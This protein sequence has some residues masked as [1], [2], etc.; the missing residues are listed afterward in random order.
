MRERRLARLAEL[1]R[2]AGVDCIALVP[3]PNLRYLTGLDLHMSERPIVAFF[4]LDGRPSMLLPAFER[5]RV[6]ARIGDQF[7]FFAYSDE[8][9]HEGAFGQ[10]AQALGLGGGRVAIEH[11]HMRV[12]ELACLR[13]AAPR[14]EWTS[15]EQGFSGLRAVKDEAEIDALRG[16]IAITEQALHTLV[17]RSLKGW[18]EKRIVD[19]LREQMLNAG[20]DGVAFIIAVAGPNGADPHAGPSERPV[21]EGDLL[22]VDCGAVVDGY[23]ADITRTFAV[24]EPDDRLVALYEVVQQANAAGKAAVRPGVMAQEVDRAARQVIHD[25]GLGRWFIHRTGHGL[26]LETHEPPYIVEG[27]AR[28]LETGMIFTVEPGVY[29]PGLGGVRIED[30]VLV[31]QEGVESLTRFDRDLM[32]LL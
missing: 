10:A 30:D 6:E 16:A 23:I 24:G 31:T 19:V 22:T 26:G 12:L 13:E 27:N 5:G 28:V 1:Q 14:A 3:G 18:T 4:P 29:V 21:Q 17:A 11:L 25:A 15:W 9:G 2:G 20:A 7:A 8:S 32:I